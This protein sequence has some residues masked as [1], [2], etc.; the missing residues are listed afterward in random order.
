ME[1]KAMPKTAVVSLITRVPRSHCR[2]QVPLSPVG[3]DSQCCKW[4]SVFDN[5][6][7]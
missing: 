6:M 2:C 4:V 1:K 5:D 7:F 3:S